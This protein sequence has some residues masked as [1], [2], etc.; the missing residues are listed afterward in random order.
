MTFQVGPGGPTPASE[1]LLLH[2]T[3][4]AG[5]TGKSDSQK[6]IRLLS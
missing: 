1:E 6:K 2:Q 4:I 3:Q 5:T